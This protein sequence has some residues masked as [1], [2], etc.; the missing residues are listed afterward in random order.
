MAKSQVFQ[1]LGLAAALVTAA[2]WAA[3]KTATDGPSTEGEGGG[4]PPEDAAQFGDVHDGVKTIKERGGPFFGIRVNSMDFA[5]DAKAIA[6]FEYRCEGLL[7]S[8]NPE[9]YQV[10]R[11][12]WKGPITPNVGVDEILGL[13]ALPLTNVRYVG[14]MMTTRWIRDQGPGGTPVGGFVGDLRIAAVDTSGGS[15]LPAIPIWAFRIRGTQG[16]RPSRGDPNDPNFDNSARDRAPLH[17]EGFYA[18]GVDKRTVRA[19]AQLF[20]TRSDPAADA[21][22]RR[23][24]NSR[25]IGTFEGTL[26]IGTLP[27]AETRGFRFCFMDAGAWRFD[28]VLGF[29]CKDAKANAAPGGP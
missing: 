16:L 24:L 27:V 3:D 4:A 29:R 10:V 28:G 15:T 7:K 13:P 12:A 9:A 23:L 20:G 6:C 21:V 19:L 2:A 14:R 26:R 8:D 1:A 22:R 5:G 17:D 11:T 18:G 25:V